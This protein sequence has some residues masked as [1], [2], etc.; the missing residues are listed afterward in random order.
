MKLR[1]SEIFQRNPYRPTRPRQRLV[2]VGV[3]ITTVVLLFSGLFAPHL[4]YLRHKL[5]SRHPPLPACAPGQTT[6]CLGGKQ[7]VMLLPAAP[8][9]SASR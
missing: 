4:R 6:D 9:P 5:E 3:T 8:A 7:G 1:L 2:I